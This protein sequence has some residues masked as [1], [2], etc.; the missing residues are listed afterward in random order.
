M[1]PSAQT[2]CTTS[3][4]VCTYGDSICYCGCQF[5]LGC[6]GPFDWICAAPPTTAGCPALVP[7]DGATCSAEGAAC[8]YGTTC[9]GSNAV[10]NCTGGL[11]IWNMMIACAG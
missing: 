10:V 4:D 6:T 8:T 1:E 9:T 2:V 3:G 7:N 5:G 11:W